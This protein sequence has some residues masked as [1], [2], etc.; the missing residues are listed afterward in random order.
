MLLGLVEPE[1][2]IAFH[3]LHSCWIQAIYSELWKNSLER[4]TGLSSLPLH[5]LYLEAPFVEQVTTECAGWTAPGPHSLPTLTQLSL[6]GQ[7]STAHPKIAWFARRRL[8][9]VSFCAFS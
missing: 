1:D 4:T 9:V 3:L 5:G 7:R 6:E 8:S 2:T